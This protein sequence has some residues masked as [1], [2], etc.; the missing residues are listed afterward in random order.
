[1]Q[2]I[3]DLLLK[4]V[5]WLEDLWGRQ[6]GIRTLYTMIFLVPSICLLVMYRIELTTVE[7][8]TR[9]LNESKDREVQCLK[10]TNAIKREVR[11]EVYEELQDIYQTFKN[12]RTDVLNE[13]SQT[14]KNLKKVEN[15]IQQIQN[16]SNN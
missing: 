1:M 10:E 11:E 5:S 16:Q 14:V 3:I 13:N 12:I 15:E 8:L 7:K 4:F 9:Q 2:L 6:Y